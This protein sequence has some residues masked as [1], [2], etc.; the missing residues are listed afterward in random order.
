MFDINYVIRVL[1]LALK[2]RGINKYKNIFDE[3]IIYGRCWLNDL[4]VNWHMNN[5]RYLRECDFGRISYLFE[6]GLWNVLSKRRKFFDKNSNMV[7]SA[8]Q[9]Q[10]RQSVQLNDKFQIRTRLN[11]WDEK[12]FYFEQSMLLE[13]NKE[14]AFSLLVRIA[15]IPRSLTPQML[16][17]DLQLGSIQ[18]PK[19]STAMNI[20]KENHRINYS[21]IKSKI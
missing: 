1:I 8:L 2:H 12:A 20:F 19:L 16:I 21:T 9:V 11:G 3:S 10:Y 6:T 4:D 13:K 18:S 14:I 7:A 17:D 15:I 5:S